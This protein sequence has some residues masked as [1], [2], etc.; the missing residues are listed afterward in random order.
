MQ[1]VAGEINGGRYLR[2]DFCKF[3]GSKTYMVFAKICP[4]SQFA[5]I[6]MPNEFIKSKIYT[7]FNHMLNPSYFSR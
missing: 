6:F 3:K 7:S 2:C 5:Y 4:F 1:Y